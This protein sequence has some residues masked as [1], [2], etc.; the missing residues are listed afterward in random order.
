MKVEE[1]LV[2]RKRRRTALA[3]VLVSTFFIGLSLW[4]GHPEWMSASSIAFSISCLALL[5]IVAATQ[6]H[7]RRERQMVPESFKQIHQMRGDVRDAR[8]VRIRNA[9]KETAKYGDVIFEKMHDIPDDSFNGI[10]IIVERCLL[11]LRTM[12]EQDPQVSIESYVKEVKKLRRSELLQI[13]GVD[14]GYDKVLE[15]ALRHQ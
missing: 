13:N 15:I 6:H 5:V 9:W 14:E 4:G 12:C 11:T 1:P 10:H 2:Y 7:I 3:A 8:D